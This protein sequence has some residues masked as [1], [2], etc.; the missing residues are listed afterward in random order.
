MGSGIRKHSDNKG[1]L[2]ERLRLQ[3]PP[4]TLTL[5]RRRGHG[6]NGVRIW[7]FGS[8]RD[9]HE[10]EGLRNWHRHGSMH[11]A[12]CAD[13]KGLCVMPHRP[14]ISI[15]LDIPHVR[16]IQ[17]ALN[18]AGKFILTVER[19]RTSTPCR[20]CGKTI[21]EHHGVDEPWLLRHLPILGHV[22]YLRIRLKRF[23]CPYC[24]GHPTTTQRLDWYDPNALH[25]K[26][27]E[28]HLILQLI[29]STFGTPCPRSRPWGLMSL[30]S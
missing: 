22:V 16:V 2:A 15:P 14:F 5:R 20:R 23:R 30:H 11:Q 18:K 13:G 28:R 27:Y 4:L 3:T 6:S 21:T 24:D 8:C 29:N 12:L 19:T 1:I 26:A 7:F 17:T 25:T 9:T 10:M